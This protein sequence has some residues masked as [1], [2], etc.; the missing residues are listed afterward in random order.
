MRADSLGL[1]GLLDFPLLL[2]SAAQDGENGS[3]LLA[4]QLF[5][6]RDDGLQ[7]EDANAKAL[8]EVQPNGAANSDTK[9]RG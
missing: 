6:D 7:V 1:T 2:E 5:L 8:S 4:C 3:V 9:G